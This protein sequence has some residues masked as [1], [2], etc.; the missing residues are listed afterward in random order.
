MISTKALLE[1]VTFGLLYGCTGLHPTLS[2]YLYKKVWR[3]G[4]PFLKRFPTSSHVA[5]FRVCAY[6]VPKLA[7]REDFE[8]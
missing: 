6:T 2:I 3:G 8:R 7:E 4:E 1:S 5:K